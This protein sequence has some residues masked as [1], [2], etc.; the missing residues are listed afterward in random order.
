MSWIWG[1]PAALAALYY[2]VALIAALKRLGVRSTPTGFSPPVS[3]LKAV[4]GRDPHFYEAIRSH[5]MLDYPDY[6][7]L[8]GVS[9]AAD[10][11]VADIERL[12]RDF[13]DRAIR[14]VC[15]RTAAPNGKAGVLAELAGQARHPILVVS[16]ADITVESGYLRT[17][18]APLA[19][20]SVGL[21]TCL[22]RGAGEGWPARLEALGIAT[23]FAPSVLVA[24]LAGV[25]EFAFGSTIAVRA[26]DLART[27]GFAAL[28]EYLADDYQLGRRISRLGLRVVLSEQVVETHLRDQTWAQVWRHQLRWARTIR[29]SRTGGYYGSLVTQATLWALVAGAA[30]QWGTAAAVMTLRLAAGLLVGIRILGDRNVARWWFL[31]PV[32]DLAG[33]A[34]WLAGG[35]GST[36]EWRGRRLRLDPGGRI[37]PQV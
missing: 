1:V 25:V 7:I 8:F 30:G 23:D 27:G 15:V 10:P 18:V 37:T 31:M 24:P 5:A 11:A 19:D 17:V 34:V 28:L 22:Y 35:V 20:P 32:R 36:V 33:F 13:P 6:E 21:V 29:V 9:D 16:D 3:I 14:L 12:Q 26:A 4:Y 2:L